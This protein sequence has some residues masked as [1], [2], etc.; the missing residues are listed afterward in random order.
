MNKKKSARSGRLKTAVGSVLTTIE[1][2]AEEKAG[3]ITR[4]RVARELKVAKSAVSAWFNGNQVPREKHLESLAR[5]YAFGDERLAAKYR[6]DLYTAAG[7]SVVSVSGKSVGATSGILRNSGTED[8]LARA[9]N[10]DR[11]RIGICTY[12]GFEKFFK[13][14][15]EAFAIYS[16]MESEVVDGLELQNFTRDVKG[17][18]VDIGAPYFATTDRVLNLHFITTPPR[19]GINAVTFASAFDPQGPLVLGPDWKTAGLVESQRKMIRPIVSEREV[20]DLYCRYR[21]GFTYLEMD[22]CEF[23]ADTYARTLVEKFLDW[24][25][26]SPAERKSRRV[27]VVFADEFTC[28][29]IQVELTKWL[30]LRGSPSRSASHGMTPNAEPLT[31]AAAGPPLVLFGRGQVSDAIEYNPRYNLA[32]CLDRDDKD[33]VTYF[34]EAWRIFLRSNIEY[35]AQEYEDIYYALTRKSREFDE[36]LKGGSDVLS[37]RDVVSYEKA[38]DKFD[39]LRALGQASRESVIDRWESLFAEWLYFRTV[40]ELLDNPRQ[41]APYQVDP[42]WHYITTQALR[43]IVRKRKFRGELSERQRKALLPDSKAQEDAS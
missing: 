42:L 2:L 30:M 43:N 6:T 34:D 36:L 37:Y 1:S 35:A 21:L 10:N 32:L 4:E 27:P 17:G 41:P 19:L 18:A 24:L 7:K 11:I 9:R 31:V 12:T 26:Y 5:F 33:W 38:A 8:R 3:R 28:L 29:E 39:C 20:G 13:D 25:S 23:G 15:L 22:R 14:I 40:L 16:G